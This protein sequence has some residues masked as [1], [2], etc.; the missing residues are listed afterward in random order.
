MSFQPSSLPHHRRIVLGVS[1][2]TVG[3][4]GGLA[5]FAILAVGSVA[6][7]V[8]VPVFCFYSAWQLL[9]N[10]KVYVSTRKAPTITEAPNVRAIH[11]AAARVKPN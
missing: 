2:A 7:L 4:I 5:A 6:A 11:Q 1:Y 8:A 9:I 3:M 10:N